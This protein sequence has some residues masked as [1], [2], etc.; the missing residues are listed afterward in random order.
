MRTIIN[1]NV[2]QLQLEF[3]QLKYYGNQERILKNPQD[4][5]ENIAYDSGKEYERMRIGSV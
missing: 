5:R 3:A 1:F 4:A 2:R